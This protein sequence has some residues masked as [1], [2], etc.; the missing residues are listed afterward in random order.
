[1]A[2]RWPR[3]SEGFAALV[4]PAIRC[5]RTQEK[6]IQACFSFIL[7]Y[8]SHVNPTRFHTRTIGER[9]IIGLVSRATRRWILINMLNKTDDPRDRRVHYPEAVEGHFVRI[10]SSARWACDMQ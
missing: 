1:M 5:S 7:T 8:P 6:N 9:R 3:A 4:L 10:Q 2:E